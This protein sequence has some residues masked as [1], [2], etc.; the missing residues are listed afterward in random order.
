MKYYL[1]LFAFFLAFVLVT[2]CVYGLLPSGLKPVTQKVTEE[3]YSVFYPETSEEN[4]GIDEKKVACLLAS[5]LGED[6][7]TEALKAAAIVLRTRLASGDD[8]I[9][10]SRYDVCAG[11][12]NA[13]DATAGMVI[14]CDG[15]LIDAAYHVSSYKMTESALDGKGNDIPYLV[16]VTSPE[17][18]ASS[19]K[20]YTAEEF[21]LFLGENGISVDE[22]ISHRSWL[23]YV[24]RTAS[25]RIKRVFVGDTELSGAAFA[26]LFG[27]ESTYILIDTTEKGFVFTSA[28]SGDGVGLSLC[29]AVKMANDGY[30]CDE[31]IKHYYKNV[32]IERK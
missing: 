11:Y 28:G 30:S 9:R 6:A 31:I 22:S 2:P 13:A 19:S 10:L 32:R 27:F 20:S 21:R 1:L 3:E 4:V 29:G 14:S 24:S 8:D 25:G 18:A 16:S 26:A 17:D 5:V 15:S 23:T 12:T 7:P